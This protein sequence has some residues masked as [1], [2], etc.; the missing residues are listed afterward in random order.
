MLAYASIAPVLVRDCARP[1]YVIGN[2]RLREI[3]DIEAFL[4]KIKQI[5]YQSLPK[6][7]NSV[8][9]LIQ[10]IIDTTKDNWN[11]HHNTIVTK[12]NDIS[13]KGNI[14]YQLIWYD[15]LISKYP[16]PSRRFKNGSIKDD[17]LFLLPFD[18]NKINYHDSCI[19]SFQINNDLLTINVD[20]IDDWEQDGKD[21]A[22]YNQVGYNSNIIFNNTSNVYLHSNNISQKITSKLNKYVDIGIY[23]FYEI[24]PIEYFLNQYKINKENIENK[25]LFLL[26]CEYN[27]YSEILII[28]ESWE[29][30]R[31]NEAKMNIGYAFVPKDL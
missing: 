13:N 27:D 15:C 11:Q 2:T 1:L 22:G 5:E 31:L 17:R 19:N 16:W 9:D 24:P 14:D 30:K 8:D 7:F 4:K 26:Q 12:L 28:S 3:M 18:F 25:R 23:N 29:I 20:L 6:E 10:N 21:S